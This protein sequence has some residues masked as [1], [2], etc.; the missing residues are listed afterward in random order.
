MFTLK[1]ANFIKLTREF[2]LNIKLSKNFSAGSK[3]LLRNYNLNKAKNLSILNSN[4][5][6]KRNILNNNLQ[7]IEQQQQQIKYYT[8]FTDKTSNVATHT[9]TSPATPDLVIE[10]NYGGIVELKLNRSQGKN[11][12]SKKLLSEVI[13]L[14]KSNEFTLIM[15]G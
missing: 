12:L 1:N 9:T 5:F 13:Y 2:Y 15:M 8:S 3:S 7:Q 14:V 6:Q 4:L 10:R 11:S